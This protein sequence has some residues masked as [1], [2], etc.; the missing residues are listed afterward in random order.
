MVLSARPVG[1]QRWRNLLF[2]HWP[3]PAAAL[4]PLVPRQLHLDLY[5]GRAYVSLIPFFVAESRP[6]GLPGTL[7]ARFLETNLRT[8]VRSADGEAGIYFFSLDASSRLAVGLARLL[9]GLPY[10]PAVMSMRTEGLRTEYAS[11]RQGAHDARLEVE[12]M[13]GSPLGSARAGTEDHFLIERYSLY[14]RRGGAIYRARVRHGAYPLQEVTIEY[15]SETLLGAAGL[16]APSD[17]PLYHYSP[18]VDVDI[19]WL[20]RVGS[21]GAKLFARA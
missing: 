17:P 9:Y 20:E 4:R 19:F 18:G 13:L 14:V 16:P 2:I 7:A 6:R 10:F 8:Y 21:G 15:L 12:W 3:V 11:R 5:E 1:Y